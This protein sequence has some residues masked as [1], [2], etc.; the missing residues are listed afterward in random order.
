MLRLVANALTELP[1]LDP[2]LPPLAGRYGGEEFAVTLQA[3]E[4]AR[5]IEL[6]EGLRQELEQRRFVMR[7][8]GQPLGTITITIGVA[9]RARGEPP[10]DAIRRADI[11]LYRAKRR[12]RNRV[13]LAELDP[14]G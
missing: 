8:S 1:G 11:A 10:I 9:E 6:A 13:E 14:V 4:A 12:G 7:G 2:E 5:A 3:V